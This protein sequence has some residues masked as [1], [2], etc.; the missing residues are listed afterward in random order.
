MKVNR[1]LRLISQLKVTQAVN[2]V[3]FSNKDVKTVIRILFS[4]F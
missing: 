2:S 3:Q 1:I 4:V